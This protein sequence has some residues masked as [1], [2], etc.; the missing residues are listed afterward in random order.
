ML[1]KNKVINLPKGKVIKFLKRNKKLKFGEIYFSFLNPLVTKAWKMHTDFNMYVAIP[2]GKVNI[3]I[4]RDRRNI[5]SYILD[6]SKSILIKKKNW[7]GFKN[8]SKKKVLLICFLDKIYNKK[9]YHQ[10]SPK[11]FLKVK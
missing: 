2:Y 6:E 5:K 3:S 7:Y 4:S 8:L 10:I 9:N 11:N 1:K